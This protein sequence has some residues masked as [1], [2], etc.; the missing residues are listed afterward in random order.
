M[1]R[2]TLNSLA[3]GM[4]SEGSP[5]EKK[6]WSTRQP[7]GTFPVGISQV[8]DSGEVLSDACASSKVSA[9]DARISPWPAR[10]RNCRRETAI[11]DRAK[12]SVNDSFET[13]RA[14]TI[15]QIVLKL[16]TIYPDRHD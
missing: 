3:K 16:S 12:E 6:P 9:K 1:G 10:F 5:G 15:D 13:T 7:I 14:V 4:R 8:A 11:S 2:K